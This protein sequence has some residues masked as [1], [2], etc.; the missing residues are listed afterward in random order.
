MVNESIKISGPVELA[1]PIKIYGH[2]GCRKK[3]GIAENSLAA[4][5]VALKKADGVELDVFLTA[6]Q[7]LVVF[8]DETL[9]KLSNGS[10]SI[11][12][13]SLAQLQ[14]FVLRERF[15]SDIFTQDR[16]PTLDEVLD[17][18]ETYRAAR[19]KDHR[20]KDF[21]VCIEIKGLGIA[22]IVA[23]TIEKRANQKGSDW[24][25]K[26]FEVRSFD[27]PSLNEMKNTMPNIQLGVLLAGP[28][29]PWD[30]NVQE[31]EA[32]LVANHNLFDESAKPRANNTVSITLNSLTDQA[33]EVLTRIV[34]LHP[35][36]GKPRATPWTASEK[37]PTT[38]A[39]ND[40]WELVKKVENIVGKGGALITD[41]PEEMKEIIDMYR[42]KTASGSAA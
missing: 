26:N 23:K 8:H 16:I 39:P 19:P 17:L 40:Q 18:V 21:K 13:H 1:A 6:D 30:I 10:G 37:N 7:H 33:I 34:G 11:T 38:F 22:G 29:H 15:D 14:K 27:M 36:D 4:F 42:G 28:K 12:S 5:N 31:L 3:K 20:L 32:K 9:E 41:F 35:D 24:G 2:R 25:I